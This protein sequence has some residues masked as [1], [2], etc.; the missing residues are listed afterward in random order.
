VKKILDKKFFCP[1]KIWGGKKQLTPSPNAFLTQGAT[2]KTN[3]ILTSTCLFFATPCSLK[4]TL[5]PSMC[6]IQHHIS[7]QQP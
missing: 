7:G 5:S 4:Q 2:S 3:S 6:S 1:A